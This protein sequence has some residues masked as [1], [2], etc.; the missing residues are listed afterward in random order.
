MA[1]G[2]VLLTLTV[3]VA[4]FSFTRGLD[5]DVVVYPVMSTVATVFI[6]LCYVVTLNV[7]FYSDFGKWAIAFL[8]IAHLIFILY[9][10]PRNL[11]DR[12][13]IKTIK[14]SLAA[15]IIVALIVNVTGTILR[16]ISR[17][18][19]DR[20]EFYT[21]YPAL[22]GLVSDVGSVVG[23]TATTKLALGLLKPKLSSIWQH[24][25][26]I[27]SAWIASLVMFVV[28]ALA[29]LL[30]HG[31]FTP[32]A[33]YSHLVVLLVANVIAVT[34]IVLVSFAVSIITFQKGLDPGNFVIPIENSFAASVTS[35][36][37]LVALVLLGFG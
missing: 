32:E 5:P 19:N 4:F 6:T 22:I 8:G 35:V 3:K 15:L 27:I 23:T 29:G 9:I 18:A 30:I 33:F 25:K 37:L 20:R 28:L 21:V 10:L 17:Y 11:R 1:I 12:D 13:F 2:L 36:A 7:F 26:S 31:I 14:E 24:A 34:L 16:G